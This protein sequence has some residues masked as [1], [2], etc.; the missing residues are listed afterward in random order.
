MRPFVKITVFLIAFP[1]VLL[2]ENAS[3]QNNTATLSPP[4][5]QDPRV[6]MSITPY[7][8]KKLLAYSEPRI[9]IGG[10]FADE[11]PIT[12]NKWTVQEVFPHNSF[13]GSET[14]VRIRPTDDSQGRVVND[15]WFK[16][17]DNGKYQEYIPKILK[18]TE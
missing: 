10:W 14:W 5:L 17:K 16:W 11:I 15:L 12:K 4:I 8:Q 18:L 3:A 2:S 13:W 6:G 1:I 7:G 9:G